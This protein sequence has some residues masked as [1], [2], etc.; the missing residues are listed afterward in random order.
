MT[1]LLELDTDLRQLLK[2]AGSSDT[3]SSDAGSS[4]LAA[5]HPEGIASSFEHADAAAEHAAAAAA[6]A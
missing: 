1:L 4:E 5:A 6:A 3:G 2:L